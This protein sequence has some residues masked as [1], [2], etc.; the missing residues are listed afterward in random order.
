M[1][2][3]AATL[4]FYF[5]AEVSVCSPFVLQ[6]V[7][8]TSFTQRA[9]A[10]VVRIHDEYGMHSMFQPGFPGLLE[11]IYV[12]E[13]LVERIMPAVYKSFVSLD[14]K[15]RSF[16]LVESALSAANE[17]DFFHFLRD[18]VVHHFVRQLFPLSDSAPHLGRLL[19]RRPRRSGNRR[20]GDHLGS[21]RYILYLLRPTLQGRPLPLIITDYRLSF[22]PTCKL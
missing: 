21:Q 4:L 8:N 19:L 5:N 3:I 12:Q 15:M 16:L 17:Y 11:A 2:P 10:D 1:G 14:S 9:Y 22:I 18:Q 20:R 13:R 7:S 6:Y